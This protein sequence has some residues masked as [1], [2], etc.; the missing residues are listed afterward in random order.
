MSVRT[1]FFQEYSPRY[2]ALVIWRKQC[3]PPLN[4][5][6]ALDRDEWSAL[7]V[8][9][10]SVASKSNDENQI[11]TMKLSKEQLT[12]VNKISLA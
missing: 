7:I 4:R 11:M 1:L 3:F 2:P 12:M 5:L 10:I 6:T 9:K 8:I